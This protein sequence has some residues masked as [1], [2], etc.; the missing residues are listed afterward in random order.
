LLLSLFPCALRGPAKRTLDCSPLNLSHDT[1]GIVTVD[2][3]RQRFKSLAA[4][5]PRWMS[6]FTTLVHPAVKRRNNVLRDAFT[7]RTPQRSPGGRGTIGMATL[8]LAR[9]TSR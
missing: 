9:I 6:E 2:D 8:D 1:V 7:R 4:V 5:Y 3:I